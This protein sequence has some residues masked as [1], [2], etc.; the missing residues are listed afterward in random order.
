M[1][2]EFAGMVYQ[3]SDGSYSYTNPEPGTETSSQPGG[4][5]ACPSGTTATAAYHTHG[6]ATEGMNNEG[7]SP[8]DRAYARSNGINLYLGT[9]GGNFSMI[10]SRGIFYS[11]GFVPTGP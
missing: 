2:I 9:P 5:S 6:A 8:Q 10:N 4:Q 1:G 7:F 3:N 11:L